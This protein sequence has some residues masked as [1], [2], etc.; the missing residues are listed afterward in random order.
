VL[1][2]I[3]AALAGL[4]LARR[5]TGPIHALQEGAARLVAGHLDRRIAIRSGDE[6]ESLADQFNDMA[7]RL[8]ASYADRFSTTL[9]RVRSYP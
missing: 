8:Q 2:L 7:G 3:G 6:L 4:A 5:M 1:A 9:W